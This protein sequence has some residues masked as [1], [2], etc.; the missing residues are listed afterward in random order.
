MALWLVAVGQVAARW[1]ADS[2]CGPPISAACKHIQSRGEYGLRGG[3]CDLGRPLWYGAKSD[4]SGPPQRLIICT[5]L[6]VLHAYSPI[7]FQLLSN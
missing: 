7:Y 4:T 3:I 2:G 5:L 1:L 6:P